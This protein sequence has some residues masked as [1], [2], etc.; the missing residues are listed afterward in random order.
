MVRLK[1]ELEL[2]LVDHVSPG[3]RRIEQNLQRLQDQQM[4]NAQRFDQHRNAMLGAAAAGYVMA[5]ALA[6]PIQSSIEF[7]TQLE[8]IRQKADMSAEAIERLGRAG[9]DVGLET[10]Q[11]AGTIAGAIDSM[12]GSGAVSPDQAVAISTP[13]GKAS[14]AYE[15]DPTEMANATSAM[16]LQMGIAAE[17][18]EKAYD[19]MA[20]AGKQGSFELKDMAAEFP[21]VLANAKSLG[22][23]GEKGIASVVAWLQ[24]ARRGTATGSEAATNMSNFMGKVLAPD[25]IKNFGEAGVNIVNEMNRALEA[26]VDPIEHV[27]GI[28]N[29]LT[30]GQRDK[31]GELFADKQV[32]DFILQATKGLEEYRRIRDEA[33][34]AD[35]TV[36][37]DFQ[38]RLATPAGAIARFEASIEN[39]NIA[40]G[41]SLVPALARFAESV[42]P[43]IDGVAS[44]VD[45]NAELVAAVVEITAA[46]I[47]LR[48]LASAGGLAGALFGMGGGKDGGLFGLGG[49]AGNGGPNGKPG[50]R[51][52]GKGFAWWGFAGF[53]AIAA[54]QDYLAAGEGIK[55]R[56]PGQSDEDWSAQTK[57]SADALAAQNKALEDTLLNWDVGGFKPFQAVKAAS[58]VFNNREGGIGGGYTGATQGQIDALKAEMARLDAEIADWGLEPA[59][60]E[61]RANL[62]A[63]LAQMEAELRSSGEGMGTQ[64]TEGMAATL[65]GLNAQMMAIMDRLRFTAASGVRIPVTMSAPGGV[66]PPAGPGPRAAPSGSGT[67]VINNTFGPT[68]VQTPTNANPR[69][70]A[71]A[72]GDQ[73]GA[74]VR[75]AHTNGGMA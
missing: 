67:T 52:G 23:E 10:A 28:I 19:I 14:T 48:L 31:M 13:L 74:K 44:F 60:E 57:A 20:V 16:V 6:T 65:P 1:S 11:G 66:A 49:G 56:K 36:E 43:M 9:R 68:N 30:D 21:G 70:I 37:A 2:S 29:G 53:N 34:A 54:A 3:A 45:A 50:G 47:G 18:M 5:R 42:T 24:I 69:Q 63:K 72:M 73:V 64:M 59:L 38:A 8:D 62:Q 40:V 22:I 71:Q 25:S 32:M 4:L 15:A 55:M 7:S 58:D 17:D 12:V 51:T 39:L 33:L 46:L 35:G 61:R 75:A 41:N 26:N 27:I